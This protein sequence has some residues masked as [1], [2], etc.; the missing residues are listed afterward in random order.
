M[1]THA[2]R[3]GGAGCEWVARRSPSRSRYGAL[4]LQSGARRPG[5]MF[6]QPQQPQPARARNHTTRDMTKLPTEPASSPL[7]PGKG[8]PGSHAFA[9]PE[10]EIAS[11]PFS[12]PGRQGHPPTPC[13]LIYG[14]GQP[15]APPGSAPR[16]EA[17]AGPPRVGVV[18]IRK[19]ALEVGSS[20]QQLLTGA[21]KEGAA[22]NG[23]A[24]TAVG[25]SLEAPAGLRS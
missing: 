12:H 18:R 2:P 1:R 7:F 20:S 21:G 25:G 23:T 19:G 3:G 4:A 24:Q 15:D 14:C 8:R 10:L 13:P 6:P 9:S 22:L 11:R 17:G 5:H 16:G